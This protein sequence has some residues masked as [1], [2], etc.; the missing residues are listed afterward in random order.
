MTAAL[1]VRIWLAHVRQ[2]KP[3]VHVAVDLARCRRG[4]LV[5]GAAE[6]DT[7]AVDQV[8]PVAARVRLEEASRDLDCRRSVDVLDDAGRV[9][10]VLLDVAVPVVGLARAEHRDVEVVQVLRAVERVDRHRGRGEGRVER[11]DVARDA[12]QHGAEGRRVLGLV[13]L[14]AGAGGRVLQQRRAAD[15]RPEADRV[16]RGRLGVDQ[17]RTQ[18]MRIHVCRHV[19]EAL[20]VAG[21]AAVVTDQRL[22]VGVRAVVRGRQTVGQQHD[23]VAL[24]GDRER[25]LVLARVRRRH[26]RARDTLEC[27]GRVLLGSQAVLDVVSAQVKIGFVHRLGQRRAAVGSD[28]R[29]VRDQVRPIGGDRGDRPQHHSALRGRR[30]CRS[31]CSCC[32]CTASGRR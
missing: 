14:A 11:Q 31:H 7:I 1:V 24:A 2:G 5:R 8:A 3:R 9:E 16:G 30:C 13:E 29:N 22:D 10:L 23:E 4:L 20:A 19:V 6:V 28:R 27:G 15:F 25:A 32:C 18:V 26:A 21:A 17:A 12:R